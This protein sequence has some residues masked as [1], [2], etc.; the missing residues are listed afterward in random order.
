LKWHP[1]KNSDNKDFASEKFKK[2]SEA[3]EILSNPDKRA[4]YDRYG[5]SGP[6][7]QGGSFTFANA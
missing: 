2:I 7:F 5:H 4:N 6:E 3:Y 1:D